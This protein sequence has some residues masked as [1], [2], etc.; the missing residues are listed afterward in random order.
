M[1]RVGVLL[2]AA[3][4]AVVVGLAAGCGGKTGVPERLSGVWKQVDQQN[5]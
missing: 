5:V 1:R 2:G 4:I 3:L